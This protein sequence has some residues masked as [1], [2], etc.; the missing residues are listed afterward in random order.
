MKFIKRVVGPS[1]L[2]AGAGFTMT[3]LAQTSEQSIEQEVE[4][5]IEEVVV[6]AQ[7][8][9]QS[10]QDVPLS[11]DVVSTETFQNEGIRDIKDMGK[12]STDLEI[13]LNTGQAT[14]V[15]MRGLQQTGFAP[16]GDTL[17]A[18]HIDGIF[19]TNF[20]ALNGLMYDL[21]RVEVLSGPQGTLY[22][23]NTAAGAINMISRRPGSEFGAD[24]YVEFG[25][26][27]TRRY[28][29]GVDLPVSDGLGFRVAGTNYS[30][31]GYYTDGGGA[32]DQWG[33]RFSGIWDFSD[34]DT[35]HFT[36]DESNTGGTT[37]AGVLLG[38]DT[39]V[40][41]YVPATNTFLD[42]TPASVEAVRPLIG[43]DPYDNRAY[44]QVR[45]LAFGGDLEQEHWGVMANY[46]HHYE[47]FDVVLQASHRELEGIG[48]TAVRAV[49]A[50]YV[51]SWPQT[52][53]TDVVELRFLSDDQSTVT[54]VGGLF[55]FAGEVLHSNA[56]P[57]GLTPDAQPNTRFFPS[58]TLANGRVVSTLG[59]Y[60]DPTT[61]LSV[62]GCPCPNGFYPVNGTTEAW[63]AYGQT[64]WAPE[65]LPKWRLTAGLRYS[66]DEKATEQGY[67]VNGTLISL[68]VDGAIPAY[69][70][71]HVVYPHE[72]IIGGPNQVVP[73]DLHLDA[74][75]DWSD[76]QWRFGAQ[77]DITETAMLYTSLSTGYKSGGFA[78]GA[79]PK[80]E[81]E[82]VTAFELGAKTVLLDNSLQFNLST[83]FYDY[84]DM[85]RGIPRPLT[86]PFPIIN[87]API[88]SIGSVGNVGK[89]Y[90]SGLSFDTT[91]TP[92]D[93]DR[94]QLSATNI[95]SE[96]KDGKEVLMDGTVNQVLNEG[97]PLGDA[98][99]WQILA[100]YSHA[101]DLANGGS[102]VPLLK[103]QYQTSKYDSGAV[104]GGSVAPG[105]TTINPAQG[106]FNLTRRNF[107]QEKIPRQGIIDFMLTY[108]SPR[109]NWDITTYVHNLTDE[110]DIKTLTYGGNPLAQGA[111][112]TYGHITGTLGEPRTWGMNFNMR[113]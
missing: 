74:R 71:D 3:S 24:T 10:S 65:S 69:L 22:G 58:V 52:A 99:K 41:A 88:V 38:V 13:N 23:R 53:N 96:I 1:L 8:R 55:Y 36:I 34:R 64:E 40:R 35:L 112:G 17:A 111:T 89:V 50:P 54:W 66:Y 5:A 25:A 78:Y 91:W 108:Y 75:D 14:R 9:E 21:E 109:E 76:W 97:E 83:W 15:G 20:W 48:R 79:T 77:Y 16:T 19:L 32:M 43:A 106:T 27:N 95:S 102:L 28:D 90:L 4:Q 12:A 80:L 70:A 49:N 33:V 59:Q 93:S 113:F 68:W 26:Y 110:L 86:P 107:P 101:F 39:T 62:P 46:T 103:Y 87:N 47:S 100:R 94:I 44:E 63:A 81:P 30:R 73:T 82:T 57:N 2:A 85:E 18:V 61:G 72:A 37:E 45:G 31:D 6:T 105:V 56:V 60:P 29:A 7:R 98:P 92:T 51:Q 84:R 42:A 67:Y 104:P 11:I